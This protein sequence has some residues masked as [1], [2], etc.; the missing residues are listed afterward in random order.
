MFV[1]KEKVLADA[2]SILNNDSNPWD[3]T[4]EGN[5]IVAKWKWMDAR[6][7]SLTDVNDETKEYS[8]TVT[9]NDKG[10]WKEK[11]FQK[12]ENVN[13]DLQSGKINIGSSF[14]SGHMIG[15]SF[16]MG[17]GKDKQTGETGI[18]KYKFDTQIIKEPIRKYLTDCGWKKGGLF[19]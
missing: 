18:L 7:Y 19:F 6:F 11:E 3:V 17:F 2:S 1:E 10:K 5:S 8:F 15:K 16:T 12:R 4:V 14:N 13:I 9:L